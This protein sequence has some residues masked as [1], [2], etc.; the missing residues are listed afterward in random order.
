MIEHF[1]VRLVAKGFH[2]LSNLDHSER[3]NLF[4]KLAIVRLIFSLLV[5][6]GSLYQLEIS[7]AF[8]HGSLTEEVYMIQ[9][10]CLL[11]NNIFHAFF[12]S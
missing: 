10:L 11:T 5:S 8:G 12:P 9:P 3:F 2:Q 6:Y 7:N 4:V 1:K